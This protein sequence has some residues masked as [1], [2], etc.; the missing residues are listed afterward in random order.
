MHRLAL[1]RHIPSRRFAT[2]TTPLA[3]SYVE[4][5]TDPPL[6]HLTL[7]AYFADKILAQ[8][9]EQPALI[10]RSEKPGAHGGPAHRHGNMGVQSHLAWTFAEMDDH[11][12]AL[13]RGLIA[14]GVTKGDRVGVI[15]GNNR[16]VR[17]LLI[18]RL[19][20]TERIHIVHTRCS[21]GHALA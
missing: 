4:G 3:R 11:I 5:P 13:A 10:C 18:P 2:F 7:P 20:H 1:T 15:M 19:P 9:V 16:C 8:N 12:M 6:S 21:N 17:F 14:M